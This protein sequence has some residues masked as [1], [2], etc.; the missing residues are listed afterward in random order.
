M[1]G[2]VGDFPAPAGCPR[3][4]ASRPG[5]GVRVSRMLLRAG[6][7][8][9][10]REQEEGFREF[11]ALA[12][13][14]RLRTSLWVGLAVLGLF[15]A[16]DLVFVEPPLLVG[17]LVLQLGVAPVPLVLA[18]VLE[19]RMRSEG[20]LDVLRASVMLSVG[21]AIA[22]LPAVAFLHGVR[23]GWEASVLY[24]LIAYEMA[25]MRTARL[26]LCGLGLVLLHALL[27]WG[28]GLAPETQVWGLAFLLTANA[29]GLVG[30]VHRERRARE[31]FE[32]VARLHR[33]AEEDPLTGLLN[34]RAFDRRVDELWRVATRLRLPRVVAVVDVDHFKAYN[35]SMGH[36]AG[37]EVLEAL[38]RLF[39]E[40][41]RRPLDLAARLG[42]EE[43]AL[44]WTGE[45]ASAE[46][47]GE[48]I[49]RGV[50]ELAI[51]HPASPVGAF[52]TVS[53]GLQAGAPARFGDVEEALEGADR[54][55]YEAKAGGRGRYVVRA[56]EAVRSVG[57]AA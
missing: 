44:V 5:G 37:D 10:D 53:V 15:S 55:L 20:T 26:A 24:V 6:L 22:L 38:G 34:R 19:P 31:D 12:A 48:R 43:F 39:R 52:L 46:E 1:S 32:T 13:R 30:A 25:G 45:G 57:A 42:G 2:G 27:A 9:A 35:D 41:A 21:A 51:P 47:L 8:F 11:F 33:L 7:C 23:V 14:P 4:A 16:L 28:A 18:L 36:P 3:P 56:S 17:L 29:L 40:L 49:L 50:A 54:A